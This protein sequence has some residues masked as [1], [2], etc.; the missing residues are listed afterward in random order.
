MTDASR[1]VR[2]VLIFSAFIGFAIAASHPALAQTAASFTG[3]ASSGTALLNIFASLVLGT[4]SGPLIA[5]AI[6]LG[7]FGLGFHM[8]HSIAGAMAYPLI[9][10]FIVFTAA[11]VVQQMQNGGGGVAALGG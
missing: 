5:I 2:D 1:Y 10:G 8:H 9:G 6:A 11:W 7:G 3:G 4:W